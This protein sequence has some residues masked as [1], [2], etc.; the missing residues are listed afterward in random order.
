[1]KNSK[2]VSIKDTEIVKASAIDAE[3]VT[4]EADVQLP[5][6]VAMVQENSALRVSETKPMVS[7]TKRNEVKQQETPE[8]PVA[9]I[10]HKKLADE[11]ELMKRADVF[12]KVSVD[13]K[14]IELKG[15]RYKSVFV[16]VKENLTE[17]EFVFPIKAFLGMSESLRDTINVNGLLDATDFTSLR[18][19][20]NVTALLGID[21][22]VRTEFPITDDAA[23]V[24]KS[25][26]GKYISGYNALVDDIVSGDLLIAHSED[27]YKECKAEYIGLYIPNF[28]NKHNVVLISS[29]KMTSLCGYDSSECKKAM[30][31]WYEAGVLFVTE[32]CRNTARLQVRKQVAKESMWYAVIM[33]Q[34]YVPSEV[35]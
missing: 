11:L 1:M 4:V 9:D 25:T 28:K 32:N 27:D 20:V 16:F 12:D 23:G 17:K 35:A 22:E 15:S 24:D 26:L 8:M 14:K 3:V 5:D 6:I 21:S 7:K 29:E 34:D 13:V 18:N 2:K 31:D 30:R 19:F 10:K 33:P